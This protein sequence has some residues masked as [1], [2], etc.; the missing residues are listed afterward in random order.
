MVTEN[1]DFSGEIIEILKINLFIHTSLFV[2][3]YMQEQM[4]ANKQHRY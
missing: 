2:N 1:M 3:Q 4:K